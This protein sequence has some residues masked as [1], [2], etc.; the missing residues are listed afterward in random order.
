MK[1]VSDLPPTI[2]LSDSRAIGAGHTFVIAE[3][4]S[5]H[6]R[7][8]ETA[9]KHVKAAA[10]AGADA[11]KFQSLNVDALY[12]QPS[13]RIRSLHE[14]IDLPEDWHAPLK[15]GCDEL[16]LIFLSS[17]TYPRSVEV[18]E[19]AGVEIYKL[20][21]AQVAVYP[22]LIQ[23]VALLG[24]PV[25]LSTGLVVEDE[26]ARI[27]DIFREAGNDKF[28]ILHCNSVY[29]APAEIVHLPRMLDFRRRFGC[30][31]GFSD[32]TS[33]N[34]ASIAAVALGASV[35]ERHFTLSRKLDSPDAPLSLEP[36]E[37]SRFVQAVREAETI[38]RPDRRNTLEVEEAGFKSAI[39][40]SLLS[41]RQINAGELLSEG[42]AVLKRGNTGAG[43]DAWDIFGKPAP[44]AAVDI[45]PATWIQ[46]SQ[47]RQA[48]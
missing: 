2:G 12:H 18:M 25:V 10:E 38:C 34:A 45:P 13:E 5:N 29:P 20:A 33:S 30:Q 40:H 48:S 8:L 32:H 44:A 1:P 27:V 9:L 4:G 46:P 28:V 47:L 7:S 23:Q 3:V 22:Q 11:V 37:F 42:N 24:K 17:A 26:I 21:S 41:T 14:R 15:H 6:V 43:V 31:V 36:D 39:R 35:I 16:G 19:S